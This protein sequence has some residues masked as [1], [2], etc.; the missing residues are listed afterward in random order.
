MKHL[1]PYKKPSPTSQQ[2]FTLIELLVTIALV[3][4]FAGLAI[5]S[6]SETARQWRRDSA[7]QSLTSSLQLA[8]SEAIK[9]SR[10]IVICSSANGTTCANSNAW[11]TGWIVFVD[12]GATQLVYDAGERVLSVTPAPSGIATLTSTG[13]V[14]RLSFLPNGLMGSGATTFTITPSG[15]TPATQVSDVGVSIVGRASVTHRLYP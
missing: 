3:A 7:T 15:A 14:T 8:R 9:S 13:N 4:I 12:D 11:G 10:R 1:S 2:G 6:F 5:P